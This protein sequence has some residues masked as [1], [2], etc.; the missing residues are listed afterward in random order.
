MEFGY[1]PPPPALAAI[2]KTIWFARGSRSEFDHAE[3]IVPDGCV[4]LIFN[5]GDAF[6]HVD[7]AGGR[8]RQP[9]DLLVGP[10][11]HPTTAVPTGNV[12]LLG[13]RFWPGRTSAFLRTPMWSLTDRLI[14]LSSVVSG[15]DR[16]L[17]D[18]HELRRNERLDYLSETF[19][20]RVEGQ[21]SRLSAAVTLSLEAIEKCG[22]N[23]PIA[24][25]SAMTGMS[26]RHLERQFRD[27]VGLGAKH[28]ARIA[29]VQRALRL[30]NT[31]AALTGADIAASCGYTDQAHLIRE[32]R[33]LTGATPTRLTTKGPTLA[34]LMREPT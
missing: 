1:L 14:A 25:L 7:E 26:R 6:E 22:G 30:M 13:L 23:V 4:E 34:T 19:A 16:L 8:H 20:R 24:M 12:D 5:L 21:R 27:E 2:V 11:I 9:R 3:P 31:H 28:I 33:E 29:R 10:S 18:L 17:G 32:C 15:T